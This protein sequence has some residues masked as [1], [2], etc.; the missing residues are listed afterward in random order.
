MSRPFRYGVL[1]PHF[2]SHAKRERIIESSIAIE[3]YGFDG[4]FVRDHVVFQPHEHEDQDNTFVDPFVV[5]AAVAAVT[6]RITLGT[7]SLV[8][9]RHPVQT[10]MLATSVEY[11]AGAGR[12]LLG[13]GLGSWDHEFRAVGMG[14]IDRRKLLPEQVEILRALFRGEKTTHAGEFY[15]FENVAIRPVRGS[16][17][18]IWYCGTSEASARR[19]A[20]YCDGWL[21]GAVPRPTLAARLERMR[22]V[23][24]KRGRDVPQAGVIPFVSPARTVEEGARKVNVAEI[25]HALASRGHQPEVHAM[26]ETLEDAGGALIA[27][28]KDVIIEQ[29]RKYQA[30]GID[31]F[32]FDLRHRFADWEDCIDY[33]GANVIP[34]LKREDAA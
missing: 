33:L 29:V 22:A 31:L 17:I 18:S 7:A 3:R 26:F 6:K 8:P 15:R 30:A 4:V 12:V 28:P 1:L 10:A 2:G 23:A 21:G 25:L 24:R 34:E 14:D 20:E 19:A 32:V 27:G 9:H 16:T 5:M 13:F 11:V